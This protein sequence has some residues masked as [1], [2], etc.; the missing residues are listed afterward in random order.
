MADAFK[1]YE[2]KIK[3]GIKK[4]IIYRNLEHYKILV[5]SAK[6]EFCFQFNGEDVDKERFGEASLAI[7]AAEKLC[8]T[9]G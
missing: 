1:E 5:D 2:D 3:Q 9:K 7:E 6:Q 4:T 8:P